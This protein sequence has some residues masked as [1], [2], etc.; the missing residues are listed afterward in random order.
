MGGCAIAPARGLIGMGEA[1]P[2][3]DFSLN[4]LPAFTLHRFSGIKRECQMN[5]RHRRSP[6]PPRA[7]VMAATAA[8]W[9]AKFETSPAKVGCQ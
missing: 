1:E 6:T 3:Y 8:G 7:F 2:T 4:P 9:L 5:A